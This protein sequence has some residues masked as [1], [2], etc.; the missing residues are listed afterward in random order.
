V[1]DPR[2]TLTLYKL[3]R[4]ITGDELSDVIDALVAEDQA[5]RLA[6]LEAEG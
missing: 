1:T 5:T 6:E 3:D 4:I 2:S